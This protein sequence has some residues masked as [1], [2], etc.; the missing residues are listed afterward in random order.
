MNNKCPCDERVMI[1]NLQR[2]LF[3]ICLFCGEVYPYDIVILKNEQDQHKST[4]N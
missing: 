3:S 2:K 1:P 4:S